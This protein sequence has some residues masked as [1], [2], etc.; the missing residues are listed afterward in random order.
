MVFNLYGQVD[1]VQPDERWGFGALVQDTAAKGRMTK[2]N[3]CNSC[4]DYRREVFLAA[5]RSVSCS[6]CNASV[7]SQAMSC[8]A[9]LFP[10]IASVRRVE[11]R[12]K[13]HNFP[14]GLKISPADP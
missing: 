8:R 10:G 6:V 9:E 5:V 2:D 12:W 1:R 11:M 13:A 7:V 4:F 3:L 14:T